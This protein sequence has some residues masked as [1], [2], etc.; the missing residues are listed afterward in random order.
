MKNKKKMINDPVYGFL[1]LPGELV[2]DLLEHRYFQRLRRIKQLGMGEL[3]YPGATHSR[4]HHA[5][6]A[7]QLMSK[8]LHVLRQKDV[9]I[10][11]VEMEATCAAILLHDIGHGPFSHTLEHA[12]IKGLHHEK[13]SMLILRKMNEEMGG[14]LDLS[15]QI[16]EGTY[17]KRFLHQ[18]ISSQL[19]MDRLDYLS[20]DSFYTGVSEGVVSADRIIHMLHVKDN[21]LVVEE[22]GIYSIEKFIIARRLMYWQVY[23]HKTVLAAEVLLRQL[24][25]RAR[26]IIEQGGV[27]YTTP[28][29]Q[30]FMEKAPGIKA[31]EENTSY[32]LE[33]FVLL[34][35]TD[36]IVSIKQ[37]QFHED[38]V[39]SILSRAFVERKLPK[40]I[41]SDKPFSK[42]QEAA[43]AAELSKQYALTAE[44][45]T[46]FV[47]SGSVENNAYKQ[48]SAASISILK[49][50]GSIADVTEVSDNYNLNSLKETVRKFYLSV[51]R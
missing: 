34:D 26:F 7:L 15:I 1:T 8:A 12:L 43:Y 2:F 22:K 16:F 29:L 51:I 21:Q 25:L 24:L 38:R 37:W 48:D 40:I 41:L 27:V 23:L 18:L 6:G 42:S 3:V 4:F 14:R 39:L 13:I 11:E 36:L 35:D 47:H 31:F 44:E 45:L 28:F 33:Q 30:P 20:R 50:D 5:L 17:P 49:K 19:D 9:L 32:W 10:S 46:Y